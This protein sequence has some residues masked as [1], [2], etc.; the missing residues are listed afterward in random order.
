M[1][2]FGRK[3]LHNQENTQKGKDK[4]M[5]RKRKLNH[6]KFGFIRNKYAVFVEIV[7]HLEKR[8]IN[9]YTM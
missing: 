6:N 7:L 4:P 1:D 2:V 5:Q 3:R 9:M 8:T